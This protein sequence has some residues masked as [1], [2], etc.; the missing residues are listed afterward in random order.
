MIFKMLPALSV[1]VAHVSSAL[2]QKKETGLDKQNEYG[3][4]NSNN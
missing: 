3:I 4:K 1:T 2:W